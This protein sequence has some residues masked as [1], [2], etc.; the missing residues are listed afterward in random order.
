MRYS[1]NKNEIVVRFDSGDELISSLKEIAKKEKIKTASVVGIGAARKVELGH[2]NTKEKKYGS[3]KFE[4]MLEIVSLSGN[5]TSSE[6][7]GEP[8]V[9]IHA[10]ISDDNYA[11]YGGH[12]ISAEINPTCEIVLTLLSTTIKRKFD[13]KTGLRLQKF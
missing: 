3:K 1:A 11:T 2:Y 10:V 6:E 8:V 9:H 4:G 13:E 7:D 12:L 5:I